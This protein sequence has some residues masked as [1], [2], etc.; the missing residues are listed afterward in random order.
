MKATIDVMRK[1][2]DFIKISKS[3]LTSMK[4]LDIPV[5]FVKIQRSIEKNLN[6]MEMWLKKVYE[7]QD[8]VRL[9]IWFFF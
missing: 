8:N 9:I 6:N 4:F 3:E 7:I 1:E 5:I 2:K